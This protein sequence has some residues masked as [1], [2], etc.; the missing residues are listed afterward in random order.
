MLNAVVKLFKSLNANSHPGEIAHAVC[1]GVFLGLMPKTN[2]LWYIL[3]VFFLFL[4]INRGA[5]ILIAALATLIAPVF[6]TFLDSAGYA[7]LRFSPAVPVYSALL[8]IPFVAFTKFNNT[9]VMGSIAASLIA[10]IPLYVI[11]RLLVKLWRVVISPKI[12]Q[13][14]LYQGFM[15]LPLAAKIA[16]IAH[17]VDEGI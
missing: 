3:T 9:I 15:K 8:D 5:L 2:A 12:Y 16:G 6:D 14:K 10:Y 1:L 13:S 4:R 11:T 17:S 7:I